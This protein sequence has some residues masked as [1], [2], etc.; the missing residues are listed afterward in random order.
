MRITLTLFILLNCAALSNL[1]ASDPANPFTT[2]EPAHPR[3]LMSGTEWDALQERVDAGDPAIAF[4]WSYVREVADDC[5]V[6]EPVVRELQGRRLLGVSRL[7]LKRIAFLSM[8]WRLTDDERYLDRAV[9]EM[10]AV[11]AFSDWNQSHFLDVAEMAA[12]VAI[13]YD[14][15]YHELTPDQRARY[16]SAMLDKALT[17]GLNTDQR[18]TSWISRSN[19]WNQV[20]HGGLTLAAL[21]IAGEAGGDVPERIV[22]QALAN[23][24]HAMQEYEPDGGYPEGAGYWDY[25]TTYNVLFLEALQS[26]LGSQFKVTDPFPGFL[27]TAE[28]RAQMNTPA[29]MRYNFG[30]NTTSQTASPTLFWF[31]HPLVNRMEYDFMR[32][33]VPSIKPTGRSH[34]GRM[35]PFQLI[36]LSR[37]D[38]NG[39][40]VML[41]LAAAW[42]GKNPVAIF[43]TSWSDPNASMVTLKGGQAHFNHGHMDAGSFIYEA[44]G[45]RWALDLPRGSYHHFE[46]QGVGLWE[47]TQNGDRWTLKAWN[48]LGHNLLRFPGFNPDVDG[49]CDWL[50]QDL[51]STAPSISVDLTALYPQ[52]YDTHHREVKLHEDGSARIVDVVTGLLAPVNPQWTLLTKAGIK[53]DATG[54]TLTLDGKT[55]RVTADCAQDLQFTWESAEKPLRP[56]DIPYPGVKRLIIEPQIRNGDLELTVRLTPVD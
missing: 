7:V 16:Q 15:L 28:F 29:G 5:L 39:E 43:R 18:Y 27:E 11:S 41:P 20:C 56:E 48:T 22:V 44:D 24:G 30:D 26:A 14:W 46:S 17:L 10:D 33:T 54:A 13:G 47:M 38:L 19:N 51:E 1:M 6:Q 3:L 2:L 34:G 37:A 23:I 9:A 8:A 21:A 42:R 31:N 49:G 35:I 40:G 53:T 4:L 25:G 50:G 55:L 45:V 36:W 12:G 32:Q 52:F